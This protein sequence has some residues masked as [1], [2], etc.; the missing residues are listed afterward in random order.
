MN[1]SVI[2]Y[3]V[4]ACEGTV[5]PASARRREPLILATLI[6]RAGLILPATRSRGTILGLLEWLLLLRAAGLTAAAS[7]NFAGGL[8]G[9]VT[10]LEVL[11][12]VLLP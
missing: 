3:P 10:F 6:L 1:G 8:L 5:R 11:V 4:E 9:S 2:A 12:L 7:L